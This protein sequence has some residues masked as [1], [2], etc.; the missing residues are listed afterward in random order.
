VLPAAALVAI[1][2]GCGKDEAKP[3]GKLLVEDDH[4][5]PVQ[6]IGVSAVDFKC[7]SVAPLESVEAAVGRPLEYVEPAG[8]S[9]PPQVAKPCNYV[10][11]V[12]DQPGEWSFDIDCRERAMKDGERLMAQYATLD[13][14]TPVMVGRSGIDHHNAQILFFDD[15]APCYVRVNALDPDERLSLARLVASG[16]TRRNAPGRVSYVEVTTDV[17]T[18]NVATDD[19]PTEVTTD[20]VTTDEVTTDDATEVTTDE[21]TPDITTGDG[22]SGE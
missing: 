17:T 8:F 14:S 11:G 19:D 10:S 9:P 6:A 4:K 20:E 5:A 2:T 22:K 7:E 15:D 1:A 18:D 12:P 13:T 21:V 3:K 16:L